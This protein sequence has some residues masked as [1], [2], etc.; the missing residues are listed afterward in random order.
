MT[1]NDLVKLTIYSKVMGNITII[2]SRLSANNFK[3]EFKAVMISPNDIMEVSGR[4]NHVDCNA[5]EV[6]IEREDVVGIDIV[7]TNQNL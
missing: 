5:I 4:I 3:Q 1:N 7:E 6:V 2:T